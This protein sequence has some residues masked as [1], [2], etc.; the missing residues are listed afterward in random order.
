MAFCHRSFLLKQIINFEGIFM[1]E[2]TK[3][4]FYSGTRTIG[5]TVISIEY[6]DERIILD[7]GLTVTAIGNIMKDIKS[8]YVRKYL[9]LGILPKIDGFYSEKD[10]SEKVNIIPLEKSRKKTKVFISHIH[11][12]H[13]H[14][15]G[16]VDKSIDVYMSKESLELYNLLNNIGDKV[17][18]DRGYSTISYD[19]TIKFGDINITA[20]KVD[21]D[22]FGAV[23]YL[24]KT[25][26][27]TAVYSGD[28]RLNGNHSEWTF[29]MLEKVSKF[30]VN[31]LFLE[32][33]NVGSIIKDISCNKDKELQNAEKA[34]I[35]KI[36][37]EIKDEKATV[38]FNIY[39]RNI[40]RIIAFYEVAKKLGRKLVLELPT[41]YIVSKL[42]GIKDFYVIE[43]KELNT[44]KEVIEVYNN[45]NKLSLDELSE[46][47]CQYII[48]NSFSNIL[49]LLDIKYDKAIYIH[50][51]GMPLGDYD[52]N[53]N[54]MRDFLNRLC[55]EYKYIGASGH[56]TPC[57]LKFI[58][59]KI[60]ADWFIPIHG[61]YPENL[62]VD[63]G[64]R[65][66]PEEGKTYVFKDKSVDII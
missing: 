32:S 64:I 22:I 60:K 6:R 17:I 43:E 56:A 48:E 46:G 9:D 52:S 66:L 4:K 27:L 37:E 65:F 49:S 8:D 14:H 38:F 58:A 28:L 35:P 1:E 36:I 23:S 61:F 40:D 26:D 53:Y 59:E 51:N 54:G 29:N 10:I 21:H 42:L 30:K 55:I 7:F 39:N 33:T 45:S 41:A 12:D 19:E 25:P 13:M 16:L 18:G 34:L 5:G 63:L 62:H 24:V 57:D 47:G 11:L 20:F 15:I 31:V 2:R 50:S 44:N 3:I